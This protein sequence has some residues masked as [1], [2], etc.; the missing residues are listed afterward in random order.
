[1]IIIFFVLLMQ[2]IISK[3]KDIKIIKYVYI[4]LYINQRASNAI[5]TSIFYFN[6]YFSIITA[7]C[8]NLVFFQSL[9]PFYIKR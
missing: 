2:N 3:N 6:N 4:E 1:M 7:Y 8:Y 9:L 5:Y